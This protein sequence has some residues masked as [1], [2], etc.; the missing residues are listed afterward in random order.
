M[1]LNL[2]LVLCVQLAGVV[3][4]VLLAAFLAVSSAGGGNKIESGQSNKQRH[5]KLELKTFPFSLVCTTIIQ[6]AATAVSPALAGCYSKLLLFLLLLLLLLFLLS[7]CFICFS[8]H[9]F[10][11]SDWPRLGQSLG[12]QVE[13]AAAGQQ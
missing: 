1:L 10:C 2:A 6:P 3:F 4:S 11:L 8:R 5:N 9:L 7:G 12:V 13:L